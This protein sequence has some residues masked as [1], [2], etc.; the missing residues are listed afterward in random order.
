M[1]VLRYLMVRT[2]E[3]KVSARIESMCSKADA[4]S[5]KLR[6]LQQA[7]DQLVAEAVFDKTDGRQ[8]DSHALSWHFCYGE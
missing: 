1:V 5:I 4:S 8:E 6:G 2:K 3:L 7:S